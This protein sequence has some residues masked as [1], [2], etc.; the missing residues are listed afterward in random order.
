MRAE[1][2]LKRGFHH[3]HS[4]LDGRHKAI[5]GGDGALGGIQRSLGQRHEPVNL[6]V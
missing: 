4:S 2:E 6:E 1:Q 3:A 5:D